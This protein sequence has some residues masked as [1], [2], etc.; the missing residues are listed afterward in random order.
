MPRHISNNHKRR[1]FDDVSNQKPITDENIKSAM[2][3]I[4]ENMKKYESDRYGYNLTGYYQKSTEVENEKQSIRNQL[5]DNGFNWSKPQ[6]A[7][8]A[9]AHKIKLENSVSNKSF[10]SAVGAI[11]AAYNGSVDDYKSFLS[12]SYISAEEW[13]KNSDKLQANKQNKESSK[14]RFKDALTKFGFLNEN[15]QSSSADFEK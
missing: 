14:N 7:E 11:N 8:Y 6:L 12:S 4:V 3:L 13:V 15:E 10:D 5:Y 2:T 9:K 1:N